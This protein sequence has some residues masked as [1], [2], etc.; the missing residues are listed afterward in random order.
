MSKGFFFVSGV[1]REVRPGRHASVSF[2]TLLAGLLVCGLLGSG[3]GRARQTRADIQSEDAGNRILAI[4]A[5]G[6]AGDHKSVPLLV[7]RLEDEDEGVRFFAILALERITGERLGY[8]YA[9]PIDKRRKAIE[10][11]RSYARGGVR[12]STAAKR[13]QDVRTA[14]EDVEPLDRAGAITGLEEE[15]GP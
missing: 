15:A 8:D 2:A 5:S 9:N 13:T 4:H 7:D 1:Q 3:C 11:W 6:E 14:E 12:V 10:R